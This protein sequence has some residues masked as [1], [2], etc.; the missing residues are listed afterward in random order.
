MGRAKRI[1]RETHRFYCLCVFFVHFILEICTFDF[2][3]YIYDNSNSIA[4]EITIDD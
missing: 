4:V 1:R 2:A 3:V